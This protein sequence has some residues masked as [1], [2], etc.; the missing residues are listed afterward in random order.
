M[1]EDQDLTPSV[2]LV[3]DDGANRTI[4]RALLESEGHCVVEAKD[5]VEALGFLQSGA[6]FSKPFDPRSFMIRVKAAL[7][8][9]GVSGS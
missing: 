4:A 7:R 5:G 6:A 9:A 1:G 3:D 2:L 8:R